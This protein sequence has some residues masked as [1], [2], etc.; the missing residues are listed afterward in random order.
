VWPAPKTKAL[1]PQLL[2]T[3]WRMEGGSDGAVPV[4][5]AR[6]GTFLGC[7]ALDHLGEVGAGLDGST[8][9]LAVFERILGVL[10]DVEA[11]VATTQIARR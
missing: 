3:A 5:S 4:E 9:H 2:A 10:V 8:A 1:D 6:F 7:A 11:P